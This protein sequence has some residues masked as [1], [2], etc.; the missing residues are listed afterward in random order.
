MQRRAL[1][2]SF[3]TTLVLLTQ[4]FV[5]TAPPQAY[6][7]AGV[8]AAPRLATPEHT[9]PEHSNKVE[10]A[11]RAIPDRGRPAPKIPE[12]IPLELAADAEDEEDP[13]G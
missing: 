5:F 3:V 2:R 4:I 13:A 10:M 6:E 9:N 11:P 12:Q 8:A 1:H 7:A